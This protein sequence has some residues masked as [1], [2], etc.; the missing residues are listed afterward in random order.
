M[1]VGVG[2]GVGGVG[3]VGAGGVGGVVVVVVVV[4]SKKYFLGQDGSTNTF[5]NFGF[6]L[7]IFSNFLE[8]A[9]TNSFSAIRSGACRPPSALKQLKKD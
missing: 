2:V 8:M 7:K 3:W 5:S 9:H 6:F 1:G 4:C